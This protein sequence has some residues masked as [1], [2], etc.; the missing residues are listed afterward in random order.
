MLRNVVKAAALILSVFLAST[1]VIVQAAKPDDAGSKNKQ[2]HQYESQ[3]RSEHEYE[4]RKSEKEY[5]DKDREIKKEKKEKEMK[6][7]EGEKPPK[8][9]EKQ[10][11]RKMEQDQKELGKG[12]EQGQAAREQRN[13]W[14]RFWE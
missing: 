4:Y 11:Q 5:G 9:L 12:A 8:G 7:Q 10:Q 14:W 13:K 6:Y 1:P 3:Q 2:T